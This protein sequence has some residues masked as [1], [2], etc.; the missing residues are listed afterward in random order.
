[1]HFKRTVSY[2][3]SVVFLANANVITIGT[4]IAYGGTTYA[5]ES[6]TPLLDELRSKYDISKPNGRIKSDSVFRESIR[7]QGR[8]ISQDIIRGLSGSHTP[9]DLSKF[10]S[11]QPSSSEQMKKA[12]QAAGGVASTQ[13]MPAL[14]S[15]D[16]S[17]KMSYKE[18]GTVEFIRG[19][20]GQLVI[21]EK[22]Y[23][24]GNKTRSNGVAMNEMVSAELDHSGQKFAADKKYG[25]ENA[26]FEEGRETN[27]RLRTTGSITGDAAAYRMLTN[28]TE[29][30]N[31]TN[32]DENVFNKSFKQINDVIAGGTDY[33]S[34]C[35]NTTHA[36]KENYHTPEWHR[37]QCQQT[38]ASNK[39]ACSIER[40]VRV[41]AVVTGDGF[42]SCGVGCYEVMVG[43]NA[44]DYW[45]MG[46]SCGAFSHSKTVQINLAAGVELSSVTATGHFDDHI[47]LSVNG[48]LVFSI[49]DGI[50]D[51]NRPLPGTNHPT[52]EIA[53]RNPIGNRNITYGVKRHI[54]GTGLQTL[55]FNLDT[56]VSGGGD[57]YA[58]LRFQFN[59][60]NGK[61]F[62]DLVHQSPDGCMDRVHE[63]YVKE[64]GVK[65]M[66]ASGWSPTAMPYSFCRFD[67]FKSTKV[68]DGGYPAA[69]V[70]EMKPLYF[71]DTEK[72]TWKAN[73]ENYQCDPFGGQKYCFVDPVTNTQKCL[74]WDDVQSFPDFCGMY[75]NDP[76]CREVSRQ[77]TEGWYDAVN[78]RCF[79]ETVVYQCDRGHDVPI[80]YEKTTSTCDAMLPCSGGECKW[81]NNERNKRFNE[82]VGKS[83]LLMHMEKDRS[84]TDKAD[85]STCR[86]FEGEKEY[87]GWETTGL[88]MDCCEDPS[89][90]SII[91]YIQAATLTMKM[92]SYLASNA[93]KDTAIGTRYGSLRSPITNAFDTLKE[94][95][96]N[97]WDSI[98]RKLSS[99]TASAAGEAAGT[100]AGEKAKDGLL[101]N[102]MTTLQQ[103]SM[104]FIYKALP[105]DLA[106]LFIQKA[107]EEHVKDGASEYALT[108]PMKQAEN[109]MTTVMAVYTAY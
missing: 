52:C 94:P 3:L 109:V 62:E 103:T 92:D 12:L 106:K 32:V 36:V 31:N 4:L 59:D 56:L 66:L 104:E 107:T 48:G 14:N 40:E 24:S 9:V 38:T 77:C 93:I 67:S 74:Q 98:V 41:P 68:G 6:D 37:E 30:A 51:W 99:E 42:S 70:N 35:T 90:V 88:G 87:C 15:A 76:K 96:T 63:T 17:V 81:G 10:L 85:A 20:N 18:K 43:V 64:G 71:G 102:F 34:G 1:M 89:G 84:C 65:T 55:T 95:V 101:S 57:S 83:S 33:F 100:I 22:T 29:R 80:E 46:D 47:A 58:I 60:K 82:V 28:T 2:I 105:D 25:D 108:E 5:Q 7:Y 19:D 72:V 16:N 11:G 91:Q 23:D 49:V 45:N 39:F 53:R 97:A 69:Y 79:N 50:F 73:L 21:K 13:G 75:R 8:D 44:E 61:G 86:I 26:L 54:T 27:T 78:K